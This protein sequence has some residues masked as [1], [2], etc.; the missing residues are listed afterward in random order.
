M[1]AYPSTFIPARL[2]T[3]VDA[4]DTRLTAFL[5]ESLRVFGGIASMQVTSDSVLIAVEKLICVLAQ[6]EF[7]GLFRTLLVSIGS[8]FRAL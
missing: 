3:P 8:R 7:T 4:I 5:L 6:D 1:I 2:Q